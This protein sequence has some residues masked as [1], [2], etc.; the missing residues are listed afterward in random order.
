[1]DDCPAD[2]AP[3]DCSASADCRVERVHQQDSFRAAH[4]PPADFRRAGSRALL[5]ER[6]EDLLDD[7]QQQAAA[8]AALLER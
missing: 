5:V 2:S 4:S 6:S 8:A 3:D 1:V 7:Y